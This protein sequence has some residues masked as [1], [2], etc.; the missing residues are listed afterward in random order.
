[1]KAIIAA[2]G[3]WTRMLPIT[4]TVPKEL[5]PVWNKPTIQYI[6][7]WIS[8]WG[9]NDII[10]VTSQWKQALEDYFDKNYELEEILEKKWK[11][12]LLD[13]V[14]KPKQIANFCFL[15]QRN[16]LGF[17]HAIL[18]AKNWIYDDFFL[19]TVGDTIFNK[20]IFKQITELHNQTKKSCILL[21][22][23]PYDQTQNYWVV[24]IDNWK[25]TDMVEK[26]TPENAPSNLVMWWM[27]I[28]PKKIFEVIENTPINDEKQEILLPDSLKKLMETE[29]ILPY[30]TNSKIWDIW[31]P[32]SWLKAN[33][34]LTNLNFDF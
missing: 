27:Y 14:N 31:N 4:K 13:E 21:T 10:V 32:E 19:L 5:L 25:I 22:E 29:E 16:Q 8:Y 12:S 15:K 9:I 20:Q 1:M 26:P 33:I 24:K 6:V 28:L 23:V 17:A 30:I 3:Y 18:E 34:D 2:A 7:E 11:K